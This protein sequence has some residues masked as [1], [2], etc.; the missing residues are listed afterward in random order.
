MGNMIK[1]VLIRD[2]TRINKLSTYYNSYA[3]TLKIIL[4]GDRIDSQIYVENK[5]KIGNLL[6]VK[7]IL[8]HYDCSI[9]E[10]TVL[11]EIEQ[12]NLDESIHGIIVQLPV[13]PNIRS[14]K[15]LEKVS[16]AKDVDCLNPMNLG[17]LAQ[18]SLK[19]NLI[20][21]ASEAVLEFL[22]LAIHFENNLEKY[23]ED[24]KSNITLVNNTLDL[25]GIN[26]AILG[27]GITAGMPI[28]IVLQKCNANITIFHSKSGMIK[29]KV[30]QAD[31][32][33]TAIGMIPNLIDEDYIKKDAIVID[34]G[35]NVI[36]KEDNKNLIKGD[37]N[38]DKVF[39][40]VKYITPM[41][42]GVGRITVLMLMRNVI[43]S[44]FKIGK[45]HIK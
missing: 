3:P 20:A 10:D 39:D 16:V 34:V 38:F 22:R 41:P 32:V 5:I 30:R 37:V 6:G 4:I 1:K 13:P 2:I 9:E 36:K 24:Y 25:S 7:T 15:I 12:S 18:T 45:S 23:I 8:K 19:N 44:W 14:S 29:D 26:V 21:P 43:K 35:I 17:K 31:I 27:R 42:G 28:S 40:T 11:K 33:V